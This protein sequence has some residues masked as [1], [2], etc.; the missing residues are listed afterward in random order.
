MVIDERPLVTGREIWKIYGQNAKAAFD[1]VAR[2]ISKDELQ[3][4][5]RVVVG[6]AG[7]NF[8]VRRGEIFCIMGLSG[9]GKS[10]LIRHVN[11]LVEPTAGQILIGG[12]DIG[13][14]SR[15][16]LRDLRAKK[17]SMVFQSTGLFPHWTTRDNVAFGLEVQGVPRAKRLAIAQE[18]LDLVQLGQWGDRYPSE[19]SGGMQQRVGLARAL[20]NDPELILMDEP[21]SALDPLIRRQLQEEFLSIWK[22]LNKTALFITHDLDEAI[23]IGDRIAIMKEGRFVQVGTPEEIITEPKDEYVRAF[24]QGI[25]KLRFVRA[26]TLMRTIDSYRSVNNQED[27][28]LQDY[29]RVRYDTLLEHLIEMKIKSANFDPLAVVNEE[30]NVV[31][32][33]TIA[34]I[35]AGVRSSPDCSGEE[36][37]EHFAVVTE[38]SRTRSTVETQEFRH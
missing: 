5:F 38:A 11:R 10:T 20:A 2:G 31:G 37:S 7:V 19:L 3:N 29:V 8:D 21:F 36:T 15:G 30:N 16:E 4:R 23:R 34:D 18:K 27:L 25:S 35:L 24:V 32:V 13:R 22:T 28:S 6:V 14:M 1:A 12:Q 9:S 17:V 33:I 26:H